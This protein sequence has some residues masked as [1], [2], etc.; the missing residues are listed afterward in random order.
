MSANLLVDIDTS[1]AKAK[2]VDLRKEMATALKGVAFE[3]N[4]DALVGSIQKSLSAKRLRV[5]INEQDLGAQIDAA[6]SRKSWEKIKLSIDAVS[7]SDKIGVAIKSAFMPVQTIRAK[8]ALEGG[9]PAELQ[10]LT[11]KIG[12]IQAPTMLAGNLAGEISAAVKAATAKAMDDVAKD[13]PRKARAA[14]G[15]AVSDEG[16]KVT[17]RVSYKTP[18]GVTVSASKPVDF[19]LKGKAAIAAQNS[20]L[21]VIKSGQRIAGEQAD[22]D[23]AQKMQFAGSGW[24]MRQSWAALNKS[25]ADYAVAKNYQNN[26]ALKEIAA[27]EAA[28]KADRDLAQKMQ[29]SGS[30][31]QMRQR[32]AAL[33][34]AK[35]EQRKAGDADVNKNASF[36]RLGASNE[37]ERLTAQL[38]DLARAQYLV[39]NRGLDFAISR[40]GSVAAAQIPNIKALQAELAALK[41]QGLNGIGTHAEQTFLARTRFNAPS[42]LTA[43]GKDQYVAQAATAEFGVGRASTLLGNKGFLAGYTGQLDTV[44]DKIKDVS[45][46]HAQLNDVMR[47]GHSAARGLAGSLGAMWLTWGSTVPLVAGAAIGATLKSVVAVGKDV[48]Y[49]LGF[50]SA[51]SGETAVSMSR[52]TDSLRGG[53]VGPKEAAEA[54]RGLAQ[55]GLNTAQSLSALPTVLALATAGEMTLADAALGATGVLAAFN[56]EVSDIGRVSDVF[57]KAAASSNTSV[58]GMVEAMKQASSMASKYGVSLED[59]AATLAVM[60][61]YNIEGSAAGTAYRNMLKELA[62]PTKAAAEAMKKVGIEAFDAQG[63]MKAYPELLAHIKEKLAGLNQESRLGYLNAIFGERGSKPIDAILN[64]LDGFTKIQETLRN[65]D[66]FTQGVLDALGAT[67]E[68]RIKNLVTNFKASVS[69]AF[70]D[71]KAPVD[72]FVLSLNRVFS[73]SEFQ[74]GAGNLVSS[75]ANVSGSLLANLDLVAAGSAA[76]IGLKGTVAATQG[77][78][79]AYHAVEAAASAIFGT[80]A[81]A[82]A[83]SAAATTALG[84]AAA[85]ATPSLAATGAAA[86]GAG[87]AAEGAAVGFWTL[88]RAMGAVGLVLGALAAAWALYGDHAKKAQDQALDAAEA[89]KAALRQAKEQA[90]RQ[91][92]EQADR[93]SHGARL[94]AFLRN[95]PG[96]TQEDFNKTTSSDEAVAAKVLA[97]RQA[98]VDAARASVRSLESDLGRLRESRGPLAG[99]IFGESAGK[100]AD[101]KVA[102]QALKEEEDNLREAADQLS[103]AKDSRINAAIENAQVTFSNNRSKRVKLNEELDYL[104]KNGKIDKLK[105]ESLRIGVGFEELDKKAAEE[106]LRKRDEDLNKLKTNLD[107][108]V[109]GKG[110]KK[111]GKGKDLSADIANERL[112][113]QGYKYER[114]ALKEGLQVQQ[115]MQR[116]RETLLKA[117]RT[118]GLIDEQTYQDRLS[119]IQVE[120]LTK[121]RDVLLAGQA[122]VAKGM[123]LRLG[124]GGSDSTV[125]ETVRAAAERGAKDQTQ[126]QQVA[127]L[128]SA[129][130]AKT[131]A[132][133]QAVARDV[134]AMANKFTESANELRKAEADIELAMAESAAAKS[135]ADKR[136]DKRFKGVVSGPEALISRLEESVSKSTTP[137]DVEQARAEA[138]AAGRAVDRDVAKAIEDLEEDLEG[139]HDMALASA[140]SANFYWQE[141][142]QLEAQAAAATAA[143]A[144][145]EASALLKRAADAQAKADDALRR[146]GVAG[147]RAEELKALQVRL[148]QVGTEAKREAEI[149]ADKKVAQKFIDRS[150]KDPTQGLDG[151]GKALFTMAD[152]LRQ[153]IGL[154]TEYDEALKRTHGDTRLVAEANA[155]FVTQG[156]SGVGTM[157]SAMRGMTKTGSESHR[158]LMNVEKAVR[159]AEMVSVL[160][161]HAVKLGLMKAE[162]AE[163]V[164]GKGAELGVVAAADAAETSITITGAL[165]RAAA[166]VPEVFMSYMAALGPYGTAAAGVAI[167]AVLGGAFGRNGGHAP[168]NRGTGTV[169]GDK[170]KGSESL[171]KSI[172]LLRDVDTMTM[173]YSAGMLA[174]LRN[175][176]SGMAGVAL[177][178]Y[179]AGDGNPVANS[180]DAGRRFSFTGFASVFEGTVVGK[181]DRAIGKVVNAIPLAGDLLSKQLRFVTSTKTSVQGQGITA[182]DVSM[183]AIRNGGLDAKYYADVTQKDS[184]LGVSYRKKDYTVTADAGSDVD[185]QLS[186]IFTGIGDTV[187]DAAKASGMDAAVAQALVDSTTI[188]IGKIDTSGTAEEIQTRLNNAIS[189][190]ADVLARKVL[191]GLEGFAQVGEGYYQTAVRVTASSEQARA[192]LASL[193]VSAVA[194][195]DVSSKQGDVAAELVRE[196]LLRKDRIDSTT[197]SLSELGKVIEGMDGSAQEIS[198]AYKGLTAARYS[199]R[200]M[201]LASVDASAALLRGA[202]GLDGLTSALDA[203]ETNVMSASEQAAAKTLKLKEAFTALGVPVPRTVEDFKALVKGIDT[204][205]ESGQELLGRVLTLSGEFTDLASTISDLGKTVEDEIARIRKLMVNSSSNG[206]AT[207]QSQFAI[208][209]AKARSGDTTA[210]DS[211]AGIS[212]DLLSA[213]EKQ[214]ATRADLLLMQARTQASLQETLDIVRG[215][216]SGTPVAASSSGSASSGLTGFTD[217]SIT[218]VRAFAAGGYHSGGVRIVGENGAEIEATGPAMYYSSAQTRAILSG[219]SDTED[220]SI[221]ALIA[222]IQSLREEV[223]AL[224]AEQRD[225]AAGIAAGVHQTARTL[226]HL[227]PEGDA[228]V[229]R[230]QR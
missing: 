44:K 77:A 1:P 211:L 52:F 190:E 41:A 184:F 27:E 111:G 213:A 147:S 68:G 45:V 203:Y 71:A 30:G 49:Q 46:H 106:F 202:G 164:A 216:A 158:Q 115:E 16:Y 215:S 78:V 121:R 191:P 225:Q 62:T 169:A 69:N 81:A 157:V 22:R 218:R 160:K 119:D 229:V 72:S 33:N 167:A 92:K 183:A 221:G 178:L 51:L 205:T 70:T 163:K 34:K 31:R 74:R 193:G 59:T 198:K 17:Q 122:E 109:T 48:E 117:E 47:E 98:K 9:M 192:A 208:A 204:T 58:N 223:R 36:L 73:S 112:R 154:Q 61:K 39:E 26:L 96:L 207:L 7:L 64:D 195:T 185:R 13:L 89:T 114:D 219:G 220:V 144:G 4:T 165:M 43:R 176:E 20:Y 153:L 93:L 127:A 123:R 201:G 42:N 186:T 113:Q 226:D 156:L 145:A 12:A 25:K 79:V 194:L 102:R 10:N 88:N 38:K 126:V 155:A 3:L 128:V 181:L 50:V 173:Q 66:G 172:D 174:S 170:D 29:F 103:R 110:G 143:G 212:Q 187:V 217:G 230:L 101:L 56:L 120:G 28:I 97:E 23:L 138:Q 139:L 210:L 100:A 129:S 227:A 152:G 214:S 21:E 141:A 5:V 14:S 65:S 95:N 76:Y 54:M 199:L 63:K 131:D 166:R 180:V 188:K 159:A 11:V 107:L 99:G 222:V 86:A 75:L 206:F 177:S 124:V 135:A 2:L 134:L 15:G 168:V 35:A 140:D 149:A 142:I 118:R 189:R 91:A 150:V 130:V 197:G 182:A 82:K 32:W 151:P 133:R 24:Q 209:T 55:N 67:T 136:E 57:T 6:L 175:I 87:V 83:G 18:A 40:V 37:V 60:A 90:D 125:A 116:E 162:V 137:T 171:T 19:G 200:S 104:L 85:V 148:E 94:V 105:G 8:V 179:G 161:T 84:R 224:R 108:P 80:S 196:S 53:M 132:G 228:L 146:A